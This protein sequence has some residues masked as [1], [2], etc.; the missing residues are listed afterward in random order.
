MEYDKEVDK[1][2]GTSKVVLTYCCF[3]ATNDK[4]VVVMLLLLKVPEVS[5]DA[6]PYATELVMTA[7]PVEY[8][9]RPVVI[10][11]ELNDAVTSNG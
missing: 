3:E 6:P 7:V 5:K 4:D 1:S 2:M 8:S 9:G 10:N 11:P